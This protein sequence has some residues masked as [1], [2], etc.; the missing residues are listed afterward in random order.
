MDF[1][2][3]K[4]LIQS[5]VVDFTDEVITEAMYH[6]AKLYKVPKTM[7]D[8]KRILFQAVRETEL[9]VKLVGFDEEGQDDVA[10][11]VTQDKVIRLR[12]IQKTQ[13]LF[14]TPQLLTKFVTFENS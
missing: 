5:F 7:I 12:F 8:Q 10:S 14:R 11:T 6:K 1:T 3:A 4:F 2:F 9:D 13:F